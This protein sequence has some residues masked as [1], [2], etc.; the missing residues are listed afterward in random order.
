MIHLRT[1]Q[2]NYHLDYDSNKHKLIDL[3]NDTSLCNILMSNG[4]QKLHLYT[5][6]EYPDMIITYTYERSLEIVFSHF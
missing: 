4:L 6:W 5:D 3:L 2:L 1:V